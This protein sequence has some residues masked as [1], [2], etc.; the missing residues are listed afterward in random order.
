MK[1]AFKIVV[2]LLLA[3]VL[4]QS[5]ASTDGLTAA[6]PDQTRIFRIEHMTCAACPITVRTAMQRVSGVKSVEVNFDSKTATVTF[7][8]ERTSVEEIAA[9]STNVGYPATPGNGS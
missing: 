6:T 1:H 4:M 5:H 2:F 3:A 8:P 9:A 7:D